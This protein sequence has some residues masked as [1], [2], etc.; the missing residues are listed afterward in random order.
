MK[1]Q[2]WNTLQAPP[3]LRRKDF[4]L[5]LA[6]ALLWGVA[7]FS[8]PYVLSPHCAEHPDTCL[9]SSVNRIDQPGLGLENSNADGFSYWTQNFSGVLALTAPAIWSGS[10]AV[11]GT[12]TPAIALEQAGIDLVL[13][14][15]TAA[16][17]GLATETAHLLTERPRPFVYSRP[18]EAQ[19]PSNYTSFYSGHTSFAAASNTAL[20]I[21]LFARQAPTFLLLLTG[22]LGQVL[23][24]STAFFR[25]LAGRHFISDVLAGAIA[26]SCIAL[27]VAYFHRKRERY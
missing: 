16:W 8:R 5:T 2:F 1:S 11:L 6:P 20:L 19:N 12:V 22:A 17:N 26:G 27:L 14:L 4:F 9:T 15:Q 24:L 7:L 21:I 23:I 10:L 18:T 13:V 3:R 25:V